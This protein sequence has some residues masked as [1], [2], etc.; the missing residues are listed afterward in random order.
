MTCNDMN[1]EK[2]VLEQIGPGIILKNIF[3]G[4]EDFTLPKVRD[5]IIK[6][7]SHSKDFKHSCQFNNIQVK[8]SWN[9][10]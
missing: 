2:N 8:S 10:N 9:H 7:Q 4:W 3:I 5:S 6:Q 1:S